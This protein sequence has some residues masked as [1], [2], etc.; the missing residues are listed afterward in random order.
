VTTIKTESRKPQRLTLADDIKRMGPGIYSLQDIKDRCRINQETGCWEWGLSMVNKETPYL[1]LPAAVIQGCEKDRTMSAPRAVWLFM[2]GSVS[3]KT[4]VWRKCS[5]PL[6]CNPEHLAAG[7][8][9]QWGQ[10]V[11]KVGKLRGDP[12]RTATNRR[13][14][15][16]Q[17]TSPDVV[18]RIEQL[19]AD[20][21][22]GPNI[23]A[24]VGVGLDVI[25]RV[26]RGAHLH[27]RVA[28]PFA[29]L[30]GMAR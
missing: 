11:A 23:S 10:W 20:G 8:R 18:Q 22:T 27:Q 4:Y 16:K 12:V 15:A 7:T 28:S 17:A 3:A 2:N 19:L 1:S 21:M 30:M 13:I 26:R 6:C 14:L 9:A 25:S 24:A 29:A 5:S